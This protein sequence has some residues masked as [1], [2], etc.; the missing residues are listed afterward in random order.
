MQETLTSGAL[1]P[2]ALDAIATPKFADR[3]ATLLRE[4]HPRT[5]AQMVRAFLFDPDWSTMEAEKGE[6]RIRFDARKIAVA[7]NKELMSVHRVKRGT[8]AALDQAYV[9][10][11]REFGFELPD[12]PK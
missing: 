10:V 12:A 5:G 6:P 3:L 8:V 1:P 7:S 2:E 11:L 4:Q 9:A